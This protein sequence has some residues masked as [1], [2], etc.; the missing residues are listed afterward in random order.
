MKN[1]LSELEALKETFLSHTGTIGETRE[2]N[3]RFTRYFEEIGEDEE[4]REG[5]YRNGDLVMKLREIATDS[6]LVILDLKILDTKGSIASSGKK[7]TEIDD[8]IFR[9]KVMDQQRQIEKERTSKREIE[10]GVE[11]TPYTS[12]KQ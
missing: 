10:I 12:L 2:I 5:E 9:L 4:L 3:N 11:S 7:V 6:V 8:L 1:S